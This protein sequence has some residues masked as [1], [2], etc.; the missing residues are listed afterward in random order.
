MGEDVH[1]LVALAPEGVAVLDAPVLGTRGPAEAGQLVTLVAG[2]PDARDAAR[3]AIE[4]WSAKVVELA[5]EPGAASRMKLVVNTWLA[6]LNGGVAEVLAAARRIGVEPA[7]FLDLVDGGLLH[8]P[9]A[10]IKGRLMLAGDLEPQFPLVGLRKD[11]ALTLAAA[12][13]GDGELPTLHGVLAA[14][15]AAAE[16][17]HGDLDM[18]AVIRA[19]EG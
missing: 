14:L 4:A 19:H 6:V 8:A 13:A 7:A 15:D 3:P 5:D 17:G 9:V 12:G 1:D 18:A 11:V 16:A 2:P 10:G